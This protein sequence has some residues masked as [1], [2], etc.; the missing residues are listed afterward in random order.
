MESNFWRY[1]RIVFAQRWWILALMAIAGAIILLGTVVQGQ[2]KSFEAVALIEPQT[3]ELRSLLPVDEKSASQESRVNNIDRISDLIQLLRSSNDLYLRTAKILRL[4]EEERSREIERILLRN[5]YF[6]SV[7]S[8]IDSQ[9]EQRVADKKIL[10]AEEAEWK[11]K[12]REEA[13]KQIVASFATS[14]D[15]QGPF[16]SGGVTLSDDAIADVIRTKMRFET[17][18]GPLSSDSAPQIVNQIRITATFERAAEAELYVNCLCIAFLDFY[19]TKSVGMLNAK[20]AQIEE[21][22]EK[23][24]KERDKARAELVAFQKEKG[25]ALTEGQQLILGNLIRMEQSRDQLLQTL[26][27]AEA[28]IVTLEKTLSETPTTIRTVLTANENPTVALLERKYLDAKSQFDQVKNSN[29]DTGNPIYQQAEKNYNDALNDWNAEKKKVFAT[30]VPNPNRGGVEQQL[31]AA[32]VE[33]NGLR[34]QL[35]ELESQ[36]AQQ[37]ARVAV[38]PAAQAELADLRQKAASAEKLYNSLVEETNR[39]QNIYIGQSRAGAMSIVSQAYVSPTNDNSVSKRAQLMMYGML[40]ALVFGVALVIGLDALDNTIQT[41]NDVEELMGLPVLGIIPA[42]LPDPARASRITYLDPLSPIAE[43]YRLMRT[44]LLFSIEEKELKGDKIRSIMVATGKPGQGATTTISNLAIALAQ[45]GKKVIL[46]D[47]DLRYPKLHNV[48]GISNKVGLSSLLEASASVDS[49]VHITEIPN[50]SVIPA[51]PVSLYPAE[52]LSSAQMK[53][54]RHEL[55]KRA[56]FVLFD[57]PSAIVF[58]DAAILASQL[59]AVLMVVRANNIPRGAEDFVRRML[60]KAKA[61]VLGVVLNAVPSEKVDSVHY[62]Q[63]YYPAILRM[64]NGYGPPPLPS[65]HANGNGSHPIGLNGTGASPLSLPG[66]PPQETGLTT[67]SDD[68]VPIFPKKSGDATAVQQRTQPA[69][70]VVG[71]PG[72]S[73]D[74]REIPAMVD[75]YAQSVDAK[76]PSLL[77]QIPWKTVGVVLIAGV[78]I[79]GLV[80]ML[81]GGTSVR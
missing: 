50:L 60:D 12:A 59:D 31:N 21:K 29:Y 15:E 62:H 22:R 55:E 25:I 1:Y 67:D 48:F 56:D 53:V 9:A 34:N 44:D 8:D 69:P 40:L 26:S 13:R 51:G 68:T 52:I 81:A 23:A 33:R 38:L 17:V 19:S 61:N 7:F 39:Y 6:A 35:N 20:I 65:P 11:Q 66:V 18:N 3:E 77:K 74:S 24:R 79:A 42:Q 43:S 46:I 70:S 37:Q 47:A 78:V 28:R 71:A 76:R 58:S 64:K 49:A 80:L 32:K 27:Q 41:T 16:A 10:P 30:T 5:G 14:K 2:K 4:N 36:I 45:I 72:A 57:T 54:V 75:R 63:N 73:G